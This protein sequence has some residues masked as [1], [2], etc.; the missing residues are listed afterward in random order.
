MGEKGVEQ[1][2]K[3]LFSAMESRGLESEEL[4]SLADLDEDERVTISELITLVEKLNLGLGYRDLKAIQGVFEIGEQ[5]SITRKEFTTLLERMKSGRSRPNPTSVLLPAPLPKSTRSV[6]KPGSEQVLSTLIQTMERQGPEVAEVLDLLQLDSRGKVTLAALSSALG[7]CYPYVASEDLMRL[8]ACLQLDRN[9][10]VNAFDAF[11]LLRTYSK[12]T[13]YSLKATFRQMAVFIQSQGMDTNAFFIINNLREQLPIGAFVSRICSL[14]DIV[15]DQAIGVFASLDIHK[16]GQIDMGDL[17]TVL[18]SYRND[19][20][21]NN[22]FHIEAVSG[23]EAMARNSAKIKQPGDF[24]KMWSGFGLTPAQI[25]QL[26]DSRKAGKVLVTD[27]KRA[28]LKLIPTISRDDLADFMTF[29]PIEEVKSAEF[30]QLFPIPEK[31]QHAQFAPN[32]PLDLSLTDRNGLTVDQVYWIKRLD[33]TALYSSIAL[34]TL[35]SA[36][37]LDKDDSVTIEELGT[38]LKKCLSHEKMSRADVAS[39]MQALDVN[40]NGKVEREE[41]L[42]RIV[43]CRNSDFQGNLFEKYETEVLNARKSGENQVKPSILPVQSNPV[44]SAIPAP[45]TVLVIDRRIKPLCIKGTSAYA[46]E[47]GYLYEKLKSSLSAETRELIYEK[48]PAES[49]VNIYRFKR[50]FKVPGG[51]T[52]NECEVTF[53]LTDTHSRDSFYLYQLLISLDSLESDLSLMPFPWNEVADKNGRALWAEVTRSAQTK[54]ALHLALGTN[55]RAPLTDQQWNAI[56]YGA[57]LPPQHRIMLQETLRPVAGLKVYHVAALLQANMSV[58]VLDEEQIM[59]ESLTMLEKSSLEAFARKGYSAI[60]VLPKEKLLQEMCDIFSLSAIEAS[61]IIKSLYSEDHPKPL[62]HL[63]TFVDMIQSMYRG[64]AVVYDLPNL[65]VA[66]AGYQEAGA[67]DLF[68]SIS[69]AF[70]GSITDFGVQPTADL[71]ELAFVDLVHTATGMAPEELHTAFHLLRF[72]DNT[73]VKAYH[74]LTVMD[75]Y[76]AQTVIWAYPKAVLSKLYATIPK[77]QTGI[78]WVKTCTATDLATPLSFPEVSAIL[79]LSPEDTQALFT[80]VDSQ[81]RG[82]IYLYQIATLVDL[83]IATGANIGSFPFAQNANTPE[84][85]RKTLTSISINLDERDKSALSYFQDSG[86]QLEEACDRKAFARRL[87]AELTVSESEAVFQCLELRKA[88]Y[89]RIYHLVACVETFCKR[90]LDLGLTP[91]GL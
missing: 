4:F 42:Q 19:E 76:K 18:D 38:M 75:T 55:L 21:T 87:G 25:W 82:G 64:P 6:P 9:Y 22:F 71:T 73:V 85:I 66:Q 31:P 78:P 84:S 81:N 1:V 89:I 60:T 74:L 59:H 44:K 35:F 3:R 58:Y 5:E 56:I 30:L 37:D 61:L 23:T 8:V 62:Y 91:G 14:F 15:Q 51:L 70:K 77:T 50:M 68:R 13:R 72:N 2:F 83:F 11:D 32:A 48:L 10:E 24:L 47:I 69:F 57:P 28:I 41:Y 7:N 80:Y 39:V 45:H 36:A 20:N 54:L 46:P 43:H 12:A 79:M 40:R 34:N 67:T 63:F 17:I 90:P 53:G 16:I 65:P 29:F 33:D 26:A 49:L 88:G 27:L 52:D 86:I